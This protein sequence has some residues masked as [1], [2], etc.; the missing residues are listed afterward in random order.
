M[1]G[2]SFGV[3]E[4]PKSGGTWV[5]SILGAYLDLPFPR[6]SAL[7]IVFPAILHGHWK[8]RLS[9]RAGLFLFR[10]G[11]DVLISL[12]HHSLREASQSTRAGAQYRRHLTALFGPSF[13]E[14]ATDKLLAKWF[15]RELEGAPIL[16]F[17]WV[18]YHRSWLSAS[19]AHLTLTYCSYEEFTNDTEQALKRVVEAI[20]LRWD[21]LRAR[22]AIERFSFSTVTGRDPGTINESSFHRSGISGAWQ[23]SLPADVNDY[24]LEKAGDVLA[25]LNLQLSSTS[26]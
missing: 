19:A 13:A 11:R 16:G 15:E 1:R 9:P 17:S 22:P 10:D 12:L 21:P 8:P 25:D 20:G 24:F 3:V 26:R 2:R 18:D 5:S 6:Q 4:F 7:P 14:T 23:S